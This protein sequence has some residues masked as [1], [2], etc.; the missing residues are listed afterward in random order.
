MVTDTYP[1]PRISDYIISLGSANNFFHI[2]HQQWV[3]ANF[4]PTTRRQLED[5]HV[6]VGDLPL[7][8]HA[9][10]INEF[11]C[12]ISTHREYPIEGY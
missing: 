12:Y 8:E 10:R 7:Q 1:L 11:I 2:G 6:S 5:F 4:H 3:L 9:A